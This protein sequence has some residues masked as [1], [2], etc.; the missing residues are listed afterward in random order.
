MHQVL[1]VFFFSNARCLGL[2]Q[3]LLRGADIITHPKTVFMPNMNIV[4]KNRSLAAVVTTTG[5]LIYSYLQNG[6]N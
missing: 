6:S 1:D 5:L 2:F 3:P 4:E